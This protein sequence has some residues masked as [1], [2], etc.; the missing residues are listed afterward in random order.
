MPK[1]SRE[2]VADPTATAAELLG[3]L[4]GMGSEDARAG[5]GRYGITVDRAFGVPVTALRGLAKTYRPDHGLAAALWATGFH[6]ARLLAAFVDDPAAVTPEQMEEWALGFD[7][8]DLTDE[9]T[10]DLF[11]VSPYGWE[12]AG[13]W[14]KRPEEYVKRGGFALMAGLAVHDR[15]AADERF[16]PLLRLVQEEA[17]D[18]RNY[19]KK[20]VS[21]ALRNIGKR[22]AALN[23]EAVAAARA[24]LAEA[25]TGREPEARSRRWIANDA[26]RELTGDKVRARL[27]IG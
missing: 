18:G 11:D 10:T 21:W 26:L 17:G 3:R 7:S 14:A 9:V 23:A 2:P 1:R 20:A 24:I 13:E 4:R 16:L 5:M 19:V 27:G 8:W 6:E 25:G 15:A 22:N 12:K